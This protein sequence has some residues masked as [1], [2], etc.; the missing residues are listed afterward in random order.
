MSLDAFLKMNRLNSRS[1]IYPGAT[2]KVA[3]AGS[4]RE[5]AA[6]PARANSGKGGTQQV[7]HKVERGDTAYA[8]AQRYGVSLD[9]FLAWN[10][11]KPDSV[12][13]PGDQ[14]VVSPDGSVKP[15]PAAG[16]GRDR[17]AEAAGGGGDR[18]EHVVAQGQ[19][20]STIARRYGVRVSDLY[21]WNGWSKQHILRVGDTVVYF[22]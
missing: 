18:R 6:P 21:R 2:L 16:E 8:I 13:R 7:Y 4:T 12:L 3:D 17:M 14:H 20:P 1:T 10:G 15:Q 5:E 11:L 19:N 22:K 9:N